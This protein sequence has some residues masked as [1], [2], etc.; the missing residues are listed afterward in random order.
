MSKIDKL[1]N[2]LLILFALLL[3]PFFF[4]VTKLVLALYSALYGEWAQGWCLIIA[5]FCG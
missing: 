5:A 3:G 2:G 4:Y 1:L